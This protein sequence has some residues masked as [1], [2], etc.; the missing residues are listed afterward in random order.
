M[1]KEVQ[2]FDFDGENVRVVFINGEPWWVAKDVAEALDYTWNGNL[3]IEHVPAEWRG[4]TSVVTPYGA[5]DMACLTEQG[6]Y[7]FLARSDK[8]KALPFQKWIAGDVLPT[9]RKTGQY[10]TK[11]RAFIDKTKETRVEFTD[12]LKNHGCNKPQHYINITLGMKDCLA[13]P[14]SKKKKEY[15]IMEYARTMAAEAVATCNIIRNNV[16]GYVGCKDESE[17]ASR[18]VYIITSNNNA[19]YLRLN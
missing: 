13:I 3:R 15:D 6:L 5:Q 14:R 7:F 19:D 16:A 8:P 9:I 12:T 1:M 4:V 10:K 2:L 11:H 17:K 18:D